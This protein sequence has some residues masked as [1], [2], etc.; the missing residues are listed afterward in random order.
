[1]GREKCCVGSAFLFRATR[2]LA[3]GDTGS[4]HKGPVCP[5]VPLQQRVCWGCSPCR[6]RKKIPIAII[7]WHACHCVDLNNRVVPMDTGYQWPNASGSHGVGTTPPVLGTERGALG[8]V[9]SPGGSPPC[10]VCSAREGGEAA[11]EEGRRGGSNAGEPGCVLGA[12]RGLRRG[13]RV[14]SPL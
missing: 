9:P 1:M 10:A 6:R 14:C 8:S 7:Q 3:Q 13:L 5:V 12:G 2:V 11:G 4:S